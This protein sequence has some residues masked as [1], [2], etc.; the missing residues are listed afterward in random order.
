MERK[1]KKIAVSCPICGSSNVETIYW[2]RISKTLLGCDK[3]I[4]GVKAREALHID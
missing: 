2:K 1:D 3:C 4:Q